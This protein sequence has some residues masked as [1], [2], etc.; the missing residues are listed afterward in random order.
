MNIGNSNA[1][2]PEKVA[3]LILY[4]KTDFNLLDF[5]RSFLI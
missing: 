4:R 3:G 2:F 5:C 1:L